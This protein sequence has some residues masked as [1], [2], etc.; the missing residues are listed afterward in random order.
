MLLK[1]L[2][3]AAALGTAA[4]AAP[5]LAADGSTI[6]PGNTTLSLSAEGRSTRA[7]DIALFSAGVSNQAR[8]AAEALAANAASMNQVVAALKQAGIEG[9]DIQTSNLSVGPV[10][11]TS[12]GSNRPKVVAYQVSNQVSV[13]ERKVAQLGKVLDALVGAGANDINGPTFALDA[14][15]AALDE[16]RSA[17]MKAAR[18]R[19]QLYAGAAGL[20][21]LRVVSISE[22]GGY[23]PR[24][25]PMLMA[26]MAMADAAPSPVEAG[27]VATSININ[28]VFELAP[29]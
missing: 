25:A 18:A 28:V 14:P 26:R 19:A 20:K 22:S 15:D 11:A 17:A 12:P 4:A 1:P 8:T 23:A 27:E 29:Q 5:A 10:Y 6:A 16:A 3:I 9:R 21:V 24:P 13:R 2:I 7:P